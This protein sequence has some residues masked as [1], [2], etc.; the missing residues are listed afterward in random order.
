LVRW[1][2]PDAVTWLVEM[3]VPLAALALACFVAR[4]VG[5]DETGGCGAAAPVEPGRAEPQFL[6]FSEPS[7]PDGVQRRFLL[8]LPADYDPSHR[9]PLVLD[10]HGFSA[11][12]DIQQANSGFANIADEH[13]FIGVW[14]DGSGDCL[15]E[16]PGCEHSWEDCSNCL[17]GWNC[18]GTSVGHDADGVPTC[19]S[20]RKAWGRYD[21]YASCGA[22]C[23]PRED[24]TTDTCL[25]SSCWDDVGFI[26]AL[27]DWLEANLCVN[28]E[29]IHLTGLSNGAMMNYQLASSHVGH[30]IASMVPVAGLPLL[31]FLNPD[32]GRW[33]AVPIR[34]IAIMDVHGLLD[35]TVPVRKTP[36]S[37]DL[38]NP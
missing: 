10:L 11:T 26:E 5:A 15:A 3:L 4:P 20:D 28:T 29:R 19:N 13:G 8:R 16:T 37:F 24:N 25:S 27:L 17:Q 1:L 6:H 34:P 23:E 36:L 18:L 35:H 2:L 30:R 31:G 32:H 7:V 21:C 33:S 38:K 22:A 12:A 9:H 14:P